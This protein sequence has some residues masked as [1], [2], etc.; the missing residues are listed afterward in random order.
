MAAQTQFQ[1]FPQVQPQN[2]PNNNPFRKGHRRRTTK[3]PV[4][5]PIVEDPKS[6]AQTEAVI[7][8]IIE[9]TNKTPLIPP[10][11]VHPP[12]T[13]SAATAQANDDGNRT[14]SPPRP[15][16]HTSPDPSSTEPGHIESGSPVQ[17]EL[18]T[19]SKSPTSPVIPMR[20]I[21]PR[22]N[23]R[24]R[25]SQQ[26][27]FPQR[28]TPDNLPREVIS[29]CDYSPSVTSPQSGFPHTKRKSTE[30]AV[31]SK[32]SSTEQLARLWEATNGEGPDPALG[33]FHLRISKA[34]PLTYT[35][36][37]HATSLYSL[38]T[39]DMNDVEIQKS[40]PTKE[41][42]KSPIITLSN[43]EIN[44][45]NEMGFITVVFPMLAEILAR[46]QALSL[47]RQHQL[48][49]TDAMEVE[50]DAV[51]RAE[52]QESCI[53]EW[54]GTHG[55]Y[56]I[57]HQALFPQAASATPD[58]GYQSSDSPTPEKQ[59]QLLNLTVSASTTDSVELGHPPSILITIPGP[60][61]ANVA[62][63][64]A[65][66]LET[67]TLSISAGVIASTIPALYSIDSLVASILL[68]AVTDQTTKKILSDM[69]IGT[70]G[71][72]TFPDPYHINSSP[73]AP[74]IATTTT[75][76]FTGKLVATQAE[77]EDAEQ[78]AELMSQ[79]RSSPTTKKRKSRFFF[80]WRKASNSDEPSSKSKKKN[81]KAPVAIEEIDLENYGRYASG[82]REGE[83]LPGVTRSALRMIFWG[84][85]LV[86]W[87]LTVAVRFMA[88][89]L[90][91]AT[92]CL[93]S[94]KF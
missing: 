2:R 3:S 46:E 15:H 91:S 94:E 78:E 34:D 79:I 93:T 28:A 65:L 33:T 7:L 81:K 74:S 63:L 1:L 35:F 25:L 24:V 36:G 87:G 12:R 62:P 43:A 69:E 4:V 16:I 18:T 21:F 51:K 54:T 29:R 75:P 86:V 40:H 58:S 49:P 61:S 10:P 13:S 64:V 56:D 22:F 39:N 68:I 84:F 19:P 48:A 83:K 52:A 42:T 37:N 66:D 60:D 20:S 27:Y 92:R 55:R 67:M 82:S 38:K 47:S 80:P 76:R 50:D 88:W 6:S 44:R 85:R 53:L 9:D 71:S 14:E 11:P 70:P 45:P 72:R 89:L 59:G 32:L 8:Q 90:V 73:K 23:P 57:R 5:S 31:A 77:R 17:I 26:F 30:L 41:H